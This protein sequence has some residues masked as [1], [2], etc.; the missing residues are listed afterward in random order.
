M[1]GFSVLLAVLNA[2]QGQGTCLVVLTSGVPSCVPCCLAQSRLSGILVERRRG[3][4][5]F[6]VLLGEYEV[7]EYLDL[8]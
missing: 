7:G 2:L 1:C 5:G 3:D 6:L 4:T 8:S